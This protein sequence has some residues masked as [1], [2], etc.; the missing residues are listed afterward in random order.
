MNKEK[1]IQE[2]EE[3]CNPVVEYLKKNHNPYYSLVISRADI[4][5]VSS[6][7]FVPLETAQ[8]VPVQ[9]QSVSNFSPQA[10]KKLHETCPK[11]WVKNKPYKCGLDKCPGYKLLVIEATA[12][13][14]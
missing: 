4:K 7:M 10:G 14:K 6:E 11:C 1:E 2:L 13:G 9:E 12:E 5:L 8:E 3:I